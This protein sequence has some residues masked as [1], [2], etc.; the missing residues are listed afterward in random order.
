MQRVAKRPVPTLAECL[1]DGERFEGFEEWVQALASR[2]RA[3]EDPTEASALRML[4][5]LTVACQEAFRRET[6]QHCQPIAD[7]L[8]LLARVAGMAA[9]AP[10]LNFIEDSRSSDAH[11]LVQI[12]VD[13]FGFGAEFVLEKDASSRTREEQRRAR[14]ELG[15]S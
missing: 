11:D 12:L 2:E 6:E 4:N 15:A 3:A 9:M 1:G 5:I 10:T 7:T 14:G 8:L 13:E